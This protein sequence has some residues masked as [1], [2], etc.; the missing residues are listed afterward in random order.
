VYG[1]LAKEL[2]EQDALA[3][4]IAAV[5]RERKRVGAQRRI[6]KERKDQI[7]IGERALAHHYKLRGKS[8][9][10]PGESNPERRLKIEGIAPGD[11]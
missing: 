2:Q 7:C 3:D 6:I 5:L 1:Q 4:R 8:V 11:N 9:G 10:R